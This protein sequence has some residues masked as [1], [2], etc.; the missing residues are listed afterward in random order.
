MR[1]DERPETAIP[2]R[3]VDQRERVAPNQDGIL[4]AAVTID[5]DD[6]RAAR[7]L[8]G[9]EQRSHG[10]RRQQRLVAEGDQG[11]VGVVGQ[12]P[13]PDLQ[14]ARQPVVRCWIHDQPGAP[15]IDLVL[16]LIRVAP[17]DHDDVIELRRLQAFEDVLEDRATLE[18]SEE[19]AAAEARTGAGG[20]HDG[21]DAS[22]VRP[23]ASHPSMLAHPSNRR[24]RRNAV[25]GSLELVGRAV[26]GV[27][28][29]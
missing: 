5:R 10:A 23:G 27:T 25:P 19:L 1:V 8:V 7:L 20:E 22:P 13:D 29:R 6:D 11:C 18:R 9:V 3:L 17:D 24:D 4:P 26:L 15:G 2:V 21:G 16:D 28:S 12:R 14:R